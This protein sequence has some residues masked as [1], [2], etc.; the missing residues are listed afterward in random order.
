V[1]SWEPYAIV[2][3]ES[4]KAFQLHAVFRVKNRTHASVHIDVKSSNTQED[5]ASHST[6]TIQMPTSRKLLKPNL[7]G[8]PA[9]RMGCRPTA[10][11]KKYVLRGRKINTWMAVK[12]VKRPER[13]NPWLSPISIDSAS[14]RS[15]EGPTEGER[16]PSPAVLLLVSSENPKMLINFS[17]IAFRIRFDLLY[18]PITEMISSG[19]MTKPKATKNASC[20]AHSCNSAAIA[21][22]SGPLNDQKFKVHNRGSIV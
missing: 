21:C 18:V 3:P 1:V 19:V 4:I 17:A 16:F 8:I 15:V 13:P 22:D 11:L 6:P 20:A 2:H 9:P 12:M 14:V 5:I 7:P 10:F